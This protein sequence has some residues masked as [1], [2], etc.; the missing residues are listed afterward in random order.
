MILRITGGLTLDVLNRVLCLF[1]K[2]IVHG[3]T[4]SLALLLKA[5]HWEL[6]P[7]A[8]LVFFRMISSTMSKLDRS[9]TRHASDHICNV[10]PSIPKQVRLKRS[11]LVQLC[12]LANFSSYSELFIDLFTH[13]ARIDWPLPRLYIRHWMHNNNTAPTPDYPESKSH[14]LKVPVV[15]IFNLFKVAAHHYNLIGSFLGIEWFQSF[16]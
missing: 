2:Q 6:S 7:L 14:A 5:V 4:K 1:Y 15:F 11:H 3:A 13:A 16:V 12:Y 10:K 9:Q 8:S